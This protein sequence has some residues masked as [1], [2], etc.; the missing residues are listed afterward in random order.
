MSTEPT[1]HPTDHLVPGDEPLDAED[2]RIWGLCLERES[3]GVPTE[4]WP[5]QRR[6][7]DRVPRLEVSL[8]QDPTVVRYPMRLCALS[9]WPTV[10]VVS[11]N[12][13]SLED[14]IFLKAWIERDREALL[15]FWEKRILPRELVDRLVTI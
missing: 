15:D 7:V 6:R 8:E 12:A 14:M 5:L 10:E 3:T 4:V 11:G 13:P 9:I 2:D 1:G